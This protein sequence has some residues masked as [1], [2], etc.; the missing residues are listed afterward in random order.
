ML[1]LKAKIGPKGQAVIPKPIRDELGIR[2]G[3]EVYFSLHQGH[4]HIEAEDPGDR[5]DR[6]FVSLPTLPGTSDLDAAA[7]KQRIHERHDDE[8]RRFHP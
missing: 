2:P 5:L 8:H 3:D 4:A 6:F 7:I 1:R